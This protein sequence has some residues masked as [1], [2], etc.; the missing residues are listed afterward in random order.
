MVD[1]AVADDRGPI[2]IVVGIQ[3]FVG[4]GFR[5]RQ[6]I[7]AHGVVAGGDHDAAAGILPFA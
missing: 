2:R 5:E 7:A 6:R 1:D 4:Q 3:A